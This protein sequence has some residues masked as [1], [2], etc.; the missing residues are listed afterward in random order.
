MQQALKIKLMK[1]I[2]VSGFL[3]LAGLSVFAQDPKFGAKAGLN[4]AR[5]NNTLNGKSDFKAG[6]NAGFLAHIHLTPAFSLQPELVYSNQGGKVGNVNLSL[7][8]INVPLLLQYNFDNGFRI[9][10]GPQVG[11]LVGVTDKIDGTSSNVFDDSDFKDIDFSVPVG[12]SYLGY[13][14]FGVDARYNIGVTKINETGAGKT[15]NNVIQFG[16]FYLFDHKHKARSK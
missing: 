15:R 9:Q 10:G 1:K 4:I 13:S 5:T 11:F 12:L 8:Y 16:L 7:H 2:I 14:G 3:L 6:L